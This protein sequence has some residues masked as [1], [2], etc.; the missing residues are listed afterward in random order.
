[1]EKDKHFDILTGSETCLPV[2]P[3]EHAL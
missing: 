1:L 3:L 2:F